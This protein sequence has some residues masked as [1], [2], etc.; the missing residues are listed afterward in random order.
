MPAGST[1][2]NK[3]HSETHNYLGKLAVY[4]AA[5]CNRTV[6]I[7]SWSAILHW[8]TPLKFFS[9]EKEEY[10]FHMGL[11]TEWTE[12]ECFIWNFL[13]RHYINEFIW[14]INWNNLNETLQAYRKNYSIISKEKNVFSCDCDYLHS[15]EYLG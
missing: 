3:S 15:T 1:A 13:L 5:E 11:K 9:I 12:F 7:R 4:M 8:F 6:R 14:M 10:L 2:W